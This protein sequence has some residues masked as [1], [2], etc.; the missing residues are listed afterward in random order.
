MIDDDRILPEFFPV[1]ASYPGRIL[2]RYLGWNKSRGAHQFTLRSNGALY[3]IVHEGLLHLA[4][5]RRLIPFV[6]NVEKMRTTPPPMPLPPSVAPP[7]G[8]A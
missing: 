4:E 7:K 1:W 5:A 6:I 2:Y 8:A 3:E